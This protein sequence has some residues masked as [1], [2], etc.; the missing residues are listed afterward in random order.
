MVVF[1]EYDGSEAEF[2]LLI[3]QAIA[4]EIESIELNSIEVQRW[5]NHYYHL[6]SW[7]YDSLY[8]QDV[9]EF[10]Y[11]HICHNCDMYIFSDIIGYDA[12]DHSPS[13]IEDEEFLE[14]IHEYQV[15]DETG[16]EITARR[17]DDSGFF[18]LQSDLAF[19]N[20][21][22][23]NVDIHAAVFES[24]S[25]SSLNFQDLNMNGNSE[26]DESIHSE[27]SFTH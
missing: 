14:H 17:F 23:N 26:D 22:N 10:P 4:A 5:L 20:A 6:M 7:N 19:E 16:S 27:W 1:W 11:G 24:S 25:E 21:M 15:R 13:S 8:D 2:N 12:L 3:D 18:M 9:A